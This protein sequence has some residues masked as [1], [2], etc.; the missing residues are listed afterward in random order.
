MNIRDT[1]REAR[2]RDDQRGGPGADTSFPEAG[3]PPGGGVS[4]L[5]AGTLLVAGGLG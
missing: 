5:A 1:H 2:R 4:A 3:G